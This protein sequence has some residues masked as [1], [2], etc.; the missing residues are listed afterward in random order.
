MS[1]L[2][3]PSVTLSELNP[4]VVN[5]HTNG[6]GRDTYIKADNGGLFRGGDR[7]KPI[8]LCKDK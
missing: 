4:K 5:Y 1:R 6:T 7:P 3:S 2:Y 8:N